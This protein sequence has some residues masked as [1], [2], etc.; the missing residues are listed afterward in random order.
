VI[1]A[2]PGV[3]TGRKVDAFAYL[4]DLLPTLGDLAGVAGPEGS[5]GLSLAPVLRDESPSRRA[6]V[7]TA[8]RNL[9]RAVRDD[10]WKLIAYPRINK[11]QLFDL[12][13]DPDELHD[14]SADPAL[15]DELDRLTTLLRTRQAEAGDDL[16][17]RSEEPQP[18]AFDFSKVR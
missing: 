16:P 17:L 11:L 9:Q 1:L 4:H 3:P 14:L 12:S 10:R 5:E 2:G 13:A 15:A 6:D 8:Y 7:F 18:E